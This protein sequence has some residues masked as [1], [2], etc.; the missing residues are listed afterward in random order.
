MDRTAS[1]VWTGSGK[2]GQG[3]LSTKSAALQEVSYSAG[4]RFGDGRGTNP[5]E[6][7]A[8]ANR[9]GSSSMTVRINAAG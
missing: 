4:T 8:A 1:A 6:L 3:R 7:I 9:G 2:D 5:E